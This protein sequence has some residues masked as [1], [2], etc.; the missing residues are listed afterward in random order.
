MRGPRTAAIAHKKPD[1]EM[2]KKH[3]A[4]KNTKKDKASKKDSDA[5]KRP[6]SA[7]FIF[8]EDF[9][10]SFKENYPD[11]KSGPARPNRNFLFGDDVKFVILRYINVQV[12]KAGGEKWKS[13][14]DADKAPYAEKALKRKAD[15]EKAVRAYKTKL[16]GNGCN[17]PRE[18]SFQSTS[19][20]HDETGQ[21][22]SS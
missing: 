11:Q 21:E 9:R 20:I 10:K 14:S 8:M 19:E 2:L 15:Y 6:S 5:P 17:E 1:A 16:N 22:A 4:E 3:K 12:G 13:M 7:F 18:E